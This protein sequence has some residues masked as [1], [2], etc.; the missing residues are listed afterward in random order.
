MKTSVLFLAVA[1]ALIVGCA[2][3]A[4]HD[5]RSVLQLAPVIIEVRSMD[6]VAEVPVPTR[7]DFP[8]RKGYAAAVEKLRAGDYDAAIADLKPLAEARPG[9][10]VVLYALAV[11]TEVAGDDRAAADYYNKALAIKGVDS[12]CCRAGLARIQA[13]ASEN[14]AA[15]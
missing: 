3:P 14:I 2:S 9:E 4:E 1:A 5:A 12:F 11:A 10:W 7:E 13:R 15:H 6:D 8:G